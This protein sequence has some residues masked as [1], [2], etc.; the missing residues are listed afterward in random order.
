MES[1]FNMKQILIQ[2]TISEEKRKK[3]LIFIVS[4]VTG[5]LIL[6]AFFYT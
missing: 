5:L 1:D 3:A 2:L 6:I 4:V